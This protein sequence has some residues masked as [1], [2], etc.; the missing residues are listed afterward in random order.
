VKGNV[1]QTK[2]KPKDRLGGAPDD[3]TEYR[4]GTRRH[5]GNT[6]PSS[7]GIWE[8]LQGVL[9]GITKKKRNPKSTTVGT[10]NR[11]RP[12][13]PISGRRGRDRGGGWT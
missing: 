10:S 3:D 9:S 7:R 5:L 6:S 2:K 4:A 11:G 13:D 1:S 8:K 12:D